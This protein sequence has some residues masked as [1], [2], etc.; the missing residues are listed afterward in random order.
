V[1]AV[2]DVDDALE[3]LTGLAAGDPATPCNETVNGRV[4]KRL[5]EYTTIRRGEPRFIRRRHTQTI[6][7]VISHN[8][9]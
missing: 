5:Y 9:L 6:R 4:A 8:G 7:V 2:R 1:Y 3:A